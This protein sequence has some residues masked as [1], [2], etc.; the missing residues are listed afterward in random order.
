MSLIDRIKN[1]MFD[2]R[3]RRPNPDFVASETERDGTGDETDDKATGKVADETAGKADEMTVAEDVEKTDEAGTVDNF[4]AE[5]E[6]TVGEAAV[7]LDLVMEAQMD[8][9]GAH[10]SRRRSSGPV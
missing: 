8:P 3:E 6:M 5:G 10:G 9:T 2:I 4:P 1:R 7:L